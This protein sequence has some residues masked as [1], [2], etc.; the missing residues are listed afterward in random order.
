MDQPEPHEIQQGQMQSP[1][2]GV[3]CPHSMDDRL[4]SSSS[5]QDEKFWWAKHETAVSWAVST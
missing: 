5:E 3:D 4:A 2:P 1:A